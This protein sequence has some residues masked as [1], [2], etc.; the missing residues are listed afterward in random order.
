MSGEVS[1]NVGKRKRRGTLYVYLICSSSPNPIPTPINHARGLR[2]GDRNG[3]ILMSS[4]KHR[5][6]FHLLPGSGAG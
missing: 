4:P 5:N 1:S 6:I 2:R 3:I